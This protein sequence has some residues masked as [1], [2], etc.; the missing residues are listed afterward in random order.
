MNDSRA[1]WTTQSTEGYDGGQW[2]LYSCGHMKGPRSSV[3]SWL[4]HYTGSIPAEVI[5]F[6][7]SSNFT[8]IA[9]YSTIST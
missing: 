5:G 4:K 9:G 2:F 7:N 8:I 1:M 6:F 3:V